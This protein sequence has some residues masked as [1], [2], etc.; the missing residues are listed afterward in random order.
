MIHGDLGGGI[1]TRPRLNDL[2]DASPVQVC[3]LRAPSGF[4][5]TTLVRDWTSALDALDV[6]VIWVTFSSLVSEPTS[7]WELVFQA[8]R[9]L[10]LF[11][12]DAD[13]AKATAS[14]SAGND[15]ADVLAW[16]LERPWEG[17]RRQVVVV[18]DAY[19]NVEIDDDRIEHAILRLT[20]RVARL[21]VV[22]TTRTRDTFAPVARRLRGAVHSVGQEALTFTT[23]EVSAL[24]ERHGIDPANAARIA[25]DT[26]GYPLALRAFLLG[27]HSPIKQADDEAWRS[28]VAED[29]LSQL[30]RRQQ[31]FVR[32]TAV[33]PYFDRAL[34]RILVD[35]DDVDDHLAALE[36]A[37]VGR[38]IPFAP[39]RPVFQYVEVARTAFLARMNTSRSKRLPE[40][41]ARSAHWFFDNG[42]LEEALELAIAGADY[43]L[44]TRVY[45]AIVLAR[46]ESYLNDNLVRYL[47]QIPAQLLGRYPVLAFARG[48]CALTS[49]S[50]RA[51]AP[52]Y[53]AVAAE[54]LAERGPGL[55]WPEVAMHHVYKTISLRILRRFPE[56]AV[57]ARR[58][59]AALDRARVG[60]Q[61]DWVEMTPTALRHF[62]YSLCLVGE[63]DTATALVDHAVTTATTPWSLNYTASYNVG[64]HAFA[65]RLRESRHA[66]TLVDPDAWPPD[67][68]QTYMNALGH[69][70]AATL[71]LDTFDFAGAQAEFDGCE[72]FLHTAEF[73]PF[74]T[75]ALMHARLGLGQSLIEAHRVTE[76]LRAAVPPP[77]FGA[78]LASDALR[79]ALAILWLA[80]SR[81]DAARDVLRGKVTYP[82]QLA[83]AVAL[84]RLLAGD[85]A[86]LVTR[87]PQ[88]ERARGHTERTLLATIT[89]AAAAAA[90]SD[91]TSTAI[92]LMR[93]AAALYDRGG[94]RLHLAYLPAEDLARLRELAVLPESAGTSYLSGDVPS[95][96]GPTEQI[97][98]LSPRER[99]VLEA[100]SEHG[101]R[102]QVAAALHI[103]ENTVKTHMSGLYRKLGANSRETALQR[104]VELDLLIG[105][106]PPR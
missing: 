81:P 37:G 86:D 95:L 38:W 59:L 61:P 14:V 85:P 66:A 42:L 84:M 1:L 3:V 49:P 106:R 53:F 5:K 34:A 11:V 101:S 98:L 26:G 31:R 46:P 62:A 79:G 41:A 103:S 4:G 12:D 94:A 7:F 33:P 100:L 10:D 16:F 57:A 23:A 8:T 18:L 60:D 89:I 76:E 30:D 13:W 39:G 75:W 51:A 44:A 40:L 17:R 90:R 36:R 73:W 78:N 69:T 58:G 68:D 105:P 6:Q 20:E 2:L 63:V 28:T 45:R 48:L 24:I 47:A 102:R 9:R 82:G 32:A 22:V 96:V 19:E 70:G 93:R 83:P 87:L 43:D 29:L 80:G 15:P 65:G 71:R 99:T 55:G 25:R 54:H 64:L 77:G 91:E 104:A 21:R 50:T 97:P 92:S 27:L 74:F 72:A 52:S 35:T 56:A 88:L 67:H